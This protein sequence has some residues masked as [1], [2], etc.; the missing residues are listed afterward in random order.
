MLISFEGIEGSGKSTQIK[1]LENYLKKQKKEFIVIREPGGTPVSEK[2][3]E[4]LLD[5]EHKMDNLTELFL[6]L[7]SRAELVKKVIIPAL[8]KKRIV[9]CDRFIDST[10]AYQ[11]YGRG[12]EKTLITLL[13]SYIIKNIKIQRTYLLDYDPSICGIRIK[14]RKMD[15]IE[16]NGIDFHKKVRE[17]FLKIAKKNKER[18]LII[19]ALD[20]IE[21]IHKKIIEDLSKIL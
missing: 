9:I 2:I 3:R 10:L 11:G 5:S 14:D 7:G 4:I 13:N 1:L 8:K 18:F 17:G 16:N 15:R 12:I 6:F 20:S 19:N 21:E